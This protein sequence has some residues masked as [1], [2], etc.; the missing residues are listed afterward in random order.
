MQDFA[1]KNLR[2][3]TVDKNSSIDYN[4]DTDNKP[5]QSRVTNLGRHREKG[6][7]LKAFP[8][9]SREVRAVRLTEEMPCVELR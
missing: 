9:Q 7:R 2:E 3:N 1:G 6:H 5:Q 4:T 8:K